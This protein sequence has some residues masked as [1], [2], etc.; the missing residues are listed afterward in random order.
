MNIATDLIEREHEEIERCIA[1]GE[2]RMHRSTA[3]DLCV[4]VE[5]HATMEDDV[6]HP[7]LAD[8]DQDMATRDRADHESLVGLVDRV[9]HASDRAEL[10]RVVAELA[11]AVRRHVSSEEADVLPAM[12]DAL[13]VARM[14]E[15]GI[16]LLDWQHRQ[17]REE[18]DHAER[19][20]ELLELTRDEL[21]ERAQEVDLD[22]RS[23]MKKA[24]LAE[25]LSEL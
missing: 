18:R 5:Q 10:R 9:R 11:T 2:E 6:L 20:D 15:L 25:A 24:E 8:V 19:F 14:N 13:G 21:Y 23:R 16:E 22:G 17:A 3:F 7:V 4:L 12:E 1:A